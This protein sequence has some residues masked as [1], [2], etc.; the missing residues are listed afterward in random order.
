MRHRRGVVAL[1]VQHLILDPPDVAGTKKNRRYQRQ[2]KATAVRAT[3]QALQLVHQ[4]RPACGDGLGLHPTIVPWAGDPLTSRVNPVT[5]H[6]GRLA[7][8]RV[9]ADTKV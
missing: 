2:D 5:Y 6:L 1:D 3:G 9:V 7:L 4:L 8:D